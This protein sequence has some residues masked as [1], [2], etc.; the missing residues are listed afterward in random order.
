MWSVLVASTKFLLRQA[1]ACAS[2]ARETED[3]EC[4]ERCLRLEQ[5]Y[6]QLA[7]SEPGHDAQDGADDRDAQRC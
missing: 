4:R 1:M 7:K 5:V 3:D 6:L 2:L